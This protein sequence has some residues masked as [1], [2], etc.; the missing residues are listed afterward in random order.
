VELDR[1]DVEGTLAFA[2]R[3][4]T[5]GAGPVGTGL[6]ES[7]AAAAAAAAA[8]LPDG[9]AFDEKRFVRTA[10]TT[11]ALNYLTCGDGSE[12]EVACLMP[13]TWNHCVGGVVASVR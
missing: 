1:L 9:T 6:A 12:N 2:E 13:A 7:E 8:V 3:V 10:V 11:H 5:A 4:F